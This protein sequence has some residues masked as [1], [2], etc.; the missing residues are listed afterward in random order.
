M[1][2]NISGRHIELTQAI[3]EYAR[4]K[5]AK[6]TRYFDRISQIDLVIEKEKNGYGVEILT[7]VEHH[8]PFVARSSDADLYACI[9][10]GVDRAV[11]QITDHK[12]KLRDNKHTHH[13]GND[14]L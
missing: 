3:E 9:D 6:I 5:V 14:T 12:S 10:H 7:D 4:K 13:P 1:Q 8:D 11:R 2:Y